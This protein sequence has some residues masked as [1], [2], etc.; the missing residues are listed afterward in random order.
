MI[1]KAVGEEM[2]MV[3]EGEVEGMEEDTMEEVEVEG[4]KVVQKKKMMVKAVGEEMVVEGV[5]E[6]MEE[7]E[8]TVK[9]MQR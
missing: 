2:V 6:G 9:V 5:V 4:E 3:V 8:V 1:V 7:V